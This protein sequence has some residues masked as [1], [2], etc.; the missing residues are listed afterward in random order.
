M[1]TCAPAVAA[2]R[3]TDCGLVCF[4][5]LVLP[6]SYATESR[7][8]E[9]DED[10]DLSPAQQRRAQA[11]AVADA[12]QRRTRA[13]TD[14]EEPV[15]QLLR[16]S[17]EAAI[18][19]QPFAPRGSVTLNFAPA[20]GAKAISFSPAQGGNKKQLKAA[21][22]AQAGALYRLRFVQEGQKPEEAIM[23]AVPAVSGWE[24]RWEWTDRNAHSHCDAWTPRNC[25][26]CAIH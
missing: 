21:L 23:A 4:L 2:V 20:R 3:A 11:Q 14:E 17:L 26:H 8:L 16:L 13:E 7:D 15:S 10:D 9:E 25:R 24:R 1:R 22:D 12:V 6:G 19:A 5:P 18:G